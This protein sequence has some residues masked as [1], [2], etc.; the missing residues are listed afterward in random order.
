MVVNVPPIDLPLADLAAYCR[1]NGII[2]MALF[3]S[4]LREDFGPENDID[5]LVTF[6]PEAG[7]SLMDHVRLEEELSEIVGRPVDLISKRGIERSHNWIR[8]VDILSSARV[9]HAE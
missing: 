4:A 3:G 7:I 6:S 5:L 2:E 1:H 9:I 8:R